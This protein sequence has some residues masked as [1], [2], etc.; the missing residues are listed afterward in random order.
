MVK[1]FKTVSLC[2][3]TH[4]Y[5]NLVSEKLILYCLKLLCVNISKVL[6]NLC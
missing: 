2:S 1:I 6:R 3:A 4:T 5:F